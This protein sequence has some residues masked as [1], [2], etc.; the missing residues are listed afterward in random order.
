MMRNKQSIDSET[1]DSPT[2]TLEKF[3]IALLVIMGSVLLAL[4][5]IP[6]ISLA[7]SEA[8]KFVILG[9]IGVIA[10]FAEF[11]DSSLGMGYGTMLT[12]ILMMLGYSP[13]NIVPCLLLSET[14]SGIL[15]GSLHHK[16][17]NADLGRGTDGRRTMYILVACSILGSLFAVYIALGL[18]KMM[19]K[20][21]I[22]VM[23]TL[24]GIFLLVG[25]S[26]LGEYSKG[27]ILGL[28][29]WAAFN[30]GISGGGYG[31]LV[32]G[33]QVLLGVPEKNAVGITSFSEGLVCL[34]GLA[35]YFFFKEGAFSSELLAPL[36]VGALVSVPFS[37]LTVKYL[38]VRVFRK[39][40]GFVTL[41]LGVLTL[42]NLLIRSMS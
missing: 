25:R 16:L 18:P 12:P 8:N 20:I 2:T 3:W 29:I 41:Y 17:G 7:D 19:V 5:V 37:T 15:A 23:I 24:V 10:F 9:I 38:P 13:L 1:S 28:G 39:S 6:D 21:Y 4:A 30:K 34:A 33:G 27:K 11:M 32:T 14:L 22:G 35:M 42:L 40:M 36:L 26:I 31:P